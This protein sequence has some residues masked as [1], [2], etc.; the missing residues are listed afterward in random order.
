MNYGVKILCNFQQLLRTISL[1]FFLKRQRGRSFKTLVLAYFFFKIKESLARS[2]KRSASDWKSI[3]LLTPISMLTLSTLYKKVTSASDLLF[4]RDMRFNFFKR[5]SQGSSLFKIS[6]VA[7]LC[8]LSSLSVFLFVYGDH[9]T[10][11]YSKF[12]RTNDE[13]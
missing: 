2:E 13:Q 8:T 9:T 5:M 6:L 4:S 1:R 12:E 10:E 11:Q 7:L 3:I